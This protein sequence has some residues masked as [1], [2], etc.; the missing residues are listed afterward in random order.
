MD[1]RHISGG[2]RVI[3]Q[4]NQ[5]PPAERRGRFQKALLR[6]WGRWRDFQG[7][8]GGVR[9]ACRAVAD[10]AHP[11]PRL[12]KLAA[13]ITAVADAPTHPLDALQQRIAAQR[14]LLADWQGA[15]EAAQVRHAR[16]IAPL[17]DAYCALL[18]QQVQRLDVASALPGLSKVER[19]ALRALI[20]EWAGLLAA[21]SR[22]QSLRADMQDIWRRNAQTADQATPPPVD[23]D[24][25]EAGN[26]GEPWDEPPARHQADD[27]PDPNSDENGDEHHDWDS[28]R[29]FAAQRR[30][31]HHASRQ[32]RKRADPATPTPSSTPSL[33]EVYRRVASS[34][35]PDR[36]TDPA[37][38]ARKTALMQEANRA[39][40]A[41][42]LLGLLEMLG[43]KNASLAPY[44]TLLA[45]Q[46]V[47]LEREVAAC[48][49]AFCAAFGVTW[50]AQLTPDQGVAALKT[51]AKQL[52]DAIAWQ[53]AALRTLPDEP[54]GLR[55]WLREE[56]AM[57]RQRVD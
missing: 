40:A 23:A 32:R 15:H 38:R 48:A 20:A 53:Q 3:P 18:A 35:H 46:L 45:E 43:D 47:A 41:Q 6:S 13:A 11:M 17:H 52:R 27:A 57:Q 55:R 25:A 2:N 24:E 21:A 26:D 9:W 19:A 8:A 1:Y 28:A 33:R 31:A 36:E 29:A 37:A 5:K 54:V 44:Q 22:A 39:Y 14:A 7:Q 49:Q 30:A 50:H 34:V 12:P 10:N 51:H 56:R 16:D 4:V 42:D